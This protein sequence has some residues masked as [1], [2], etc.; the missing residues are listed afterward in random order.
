MFYLSFENSKIIL[1][2]IFLFPIFYLKLF[3]LFYS[4]FNKNIR[5]SGNIYPWSVLRNHNWEV[6]LFVDICDFVILGL[7]LCW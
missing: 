1:Y 5:S 3:L 4:C 7:G 2:S 6:E